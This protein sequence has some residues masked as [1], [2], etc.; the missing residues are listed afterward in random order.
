MQRGRREMA[1][2]FRGGRSHFPPHLIGQNRSN[3]QT[4][5]SGMESMI[6]PPVCDWHGGVA[7]VLNNCC[8]LLHS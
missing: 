1:D 3:G 5:H 2:L 4:G 6:L 7:A 8:H